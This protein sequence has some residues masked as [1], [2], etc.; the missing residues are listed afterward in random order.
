MKLKKYVLMLSRTFPVYHYL[1]GQPTNF[2]EK[3]L[4]EKIHTIRINAK[5]WAHKI[6]EVNAGRAIISIKEWSGAPYKSTPIEIF[7][8]HKCGFEF[9]TK[10]NYGYIINSPDNDSI[11][12]VSSLGIAKNDGLLVEEFNSWF[13]K[14]DTSQ[15]LIII[16]FT[17]FRYTNSHPFGVENY[18]IPTTQN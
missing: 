11:S 14:I 15:Q 12:L 8:M 16:H 6:D 13:K 5:N 1:K 7:Q 3:L 18:L 10:N 2:K 9:V 17:D 4:A